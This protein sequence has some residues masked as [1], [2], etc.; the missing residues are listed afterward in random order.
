MERPHKKL[1]VWKMAMDLVIDVYRV[2]KTFPMEEKYS[3]TDQLR[4][5]AINTN[6]ISKMS[7]RGGAE[8]IPCLCGEIATLPLVA[9]NDNVIAFN[10][11]VL[12]S[13]VTLQKALQEIQRRNS[14]IY[15]Y[16]AQGSL[17]ELDTPVCDR[18]AIRN[19]IK[20]GL[21]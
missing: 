6:A 14:L 5:A 13:R 9:R 10:T 2:T 11:F 3:L 20:T 18:Q 1:D 8:A 4:R 16:M 12:V 17:S 19:S 7:L 15:L 21:C